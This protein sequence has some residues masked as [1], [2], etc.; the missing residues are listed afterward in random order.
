ME[1]CIPKTKTILKLQDSMTSNEWK[2]FC[3]TE[4]L[5][6]DHDILFLSFRYQNTYKLKTLFPSC[7]LPVLRKNYT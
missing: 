7:M 3:E 5:S 4:K 1:S 2:G 6:A